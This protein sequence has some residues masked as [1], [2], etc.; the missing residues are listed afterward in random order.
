MDHGTEG[1][2]LALQTLHTEGG[3]KRAE[4]KATPVNGAVDLYTIMA[5]HSPEGYTQGIHRVYMGYTQGIH[6]V[7]TDM[8]RGIHRVYTGYTRGIHRYAQGYT[9][10]IHRVYTGYTQICT[11]VYTGCTQHNASAIAPSSPFEQLPYSL[12]VL[13]EL[14]KH[15]RRLAHEVE[16]F[17]GRLCQHRRQGGGEAVPQT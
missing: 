8:H 15:L 16:S 13:L 5:P 4:M 2:S 6:G 10:G 7:Y 3:E 12:R 1:H 14:H 9:Q 17:D 11:G